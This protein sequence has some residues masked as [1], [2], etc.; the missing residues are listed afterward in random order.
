[1]TLEQ[2]PDHIL[3]EISK[4]V[5]YGAHTRASLFEL[6]LVSRR[7][8]HATERER[9]ERISFFIESR[10]QFYDELR[11][12]HLIYTFPNGRR[13]KYLRRI[14]L[15]GNLPV[16]LA[17]CYDQPSDTNFP[18]RYDLR[19]NCNPDSYHYLDPDGAKITGYPIQCRAMLNDE[20]QR[21]E[22][23]AWWPFVLFLQKTTDLAWRP[24]QVSLSNSRLSVLV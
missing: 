14:K 13:F 22:D 6:A 7:L 11:R 3:H 12:L 10:S 24:F 1:M 20:Q 9:Y 17:F 19:M 18:E 8:A 2:L 15:G 23:D 16:G 5:A 21:A 4:Y